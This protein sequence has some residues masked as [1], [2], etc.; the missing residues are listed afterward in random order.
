MGDFPLELSAVM[1]EA[2]G[3]DAGVSAVGLAWRV[4]D[5]VARGAQETVGVHAQYNCRQLIVQHETAPSF[6]NGEQERITIQSVRLSRSVNDHM[7]TSV[8]SI[9]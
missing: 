9:G 1:R 4:L 3:V 5:H 2:A 6:V 8:K 7:G